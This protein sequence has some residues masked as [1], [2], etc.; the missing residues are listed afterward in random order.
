MDQWPSNS[1]PAFPTNSEIWAAVGPETAGTAELE[2]PAEGA[3]SA[4]T[5]VGQ[6]ATP[7]FLRE[8]IGNWS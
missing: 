5:T 6:K 7:G 2:Q 4:P 1:I 8:V 3:I